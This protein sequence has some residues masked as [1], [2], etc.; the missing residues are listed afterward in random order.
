MPL[1]AQ[2]TIL[3]S[4]AVPCIK[5]A[6][7]ESVC[8]KLGGIGIHHS[9]FCSSSTT[10]SLQRG[11]KFRSFI[12]CSGQT[13]KIMEKEEAMENPVGIEFIRNDPSRLESMTVEELRK[14]TRRVGIP[15]KGRKKDL[16]SAL[17]TYSAKMENDTDKTSLPVSESPSS[18]IKMP[19][20]DISSAK[21]KAKAS[22]TSEDD[23]ENSVAVSE[24][25]QQTK[26][27]SK[28]LELAE[29]TRVKGGAKSVVTKQEL[30][31]ETK[32]VIDTN[33]SRVI[34]RASS[35]IQGNALV[36]DQVDPSANSSEPW[37]VFAHKKPQKGW[38]AYN[39]KTMRPPPLSSD[40]KSMKV[41]SWNVNGLR[42]LLKLESFSALQLAQREDFDVLCL[43]ETKIQEK[44]VE[45]IRKSLFEG[46][47]NSFWTCSVS[48]LGYSGT[49][50]ISRI[51]PIS[52]KYGLG[53][54]DH[55]SEG[56]LVTVEFDKYYLIN[57]YVPN[58]GEGLRRLAYRVNEWDTTLSNY[59][60]DLEKSKPVI[61]TG[62]LNCAHEEIDIF[63]PAGNRRSAGFTEEE[64]KSFGDNFLSRGLVDTFRK[65]HPNVVGYTYWGYRHGG[66][67]TNR[68]WRLDYFLVSES[69]ADNVHDSFILP[70][71]M[72]SD[73]CPIGLVLK[74]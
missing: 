39:P 16:V 37:T 44:D 29:S 71:I 51:K 40:T 42:A 33:R 58:S 52:V 13:E 20:I 4:A 70:D 17:M 7:R 55:D 10:F 48:K 73:H 36:V 34:K 19:Q 6:V 30:S 56:R 21:R 32:E 45:E 31:I 67:K 54:P 22:T 49:A 12:D 3:F 23:A 53:M 50:I 26:K 25:P 27:R 68:G 59:L 64:R 24:V 72:G 41:L 69:I 2:A 35:K 11:R 15:S 5:L 65:Q 9:R 14:L 66:R 8:V 62:D 38:V 46:Y 74:L 63:N 57:G 61:L 60:K 18:T 28:K 47:D 1:G 43:Q